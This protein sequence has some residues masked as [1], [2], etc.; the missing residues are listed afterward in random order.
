MI[1][2]RVPTVKPGAEYVP[3]GQ[4]YLLFDQATITPRQLIEAK[5][6]GELRKARAGGPDTTSIALLLPDGV[7]YGFSPLDEQLAIAQACRAFTTGRFLLVCDGHPL[8]DLDL[9]VA[10][11]RRT[12]LAFVTTAGFPTKAVPAA[13][14]VPQAA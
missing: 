12:K 4:C 13:A 7:S 6:R 10:L 9:P 1:A 14:D 8:V 5:V 3:G 2:L 11:S